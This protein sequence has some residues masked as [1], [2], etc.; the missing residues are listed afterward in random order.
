[1]STP[2]GGDPSTRATGP[3]G[4]YSL[5]AELLALQAPTSGSPRSSLM[6]PVTDPL[7]PPRAA[8]D[9]L[10][11]FPPGLY[12]TSSD[13]HL[14]RLL[15]VLLGD[16]GAGLLRK[17]YLTARLQSVVAT[18][19]FA[20]MDQLY[21][22]LFGIPRLSREVLDIA[23]YR[24]AA[25][26]E[27]WAVIDARDAAYRCRIEAFS[28]A[29]PLAG[30]AEG[31]AAVGEAMLGVACRVYETYL[32]VDAT[33]GNPGGAPPVAGARTYGDVEDEYVYYQEIERGSYAE[34]EGGSGDF[35]RTTTQG[36]GEFVLRPQRPISAEETY[37]LTKVLTRLKPAQALPTIDPA[38]VAVHTPATVRAVSADSVHWE[39]R[40]RVAPQ[41]AVAKA[42]STPAGVPSAQPR[43]VHA[44]YQGEAW[45]YNSDVKTTSAYTESA[46]GARVSDVDYERVIGPT[47]R[48][49]DLTPDR[50]VA[51]ADAIRRGRAASD[52]IVVGSSYD[53]A[54]G[55]AVPA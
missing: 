48:P 39:V 24:D 1:V 47:G 4:R 15:K 25:T 30:T 44:G 37:A 31:M 27:E 26:P 42:Y 3:G 55:T 20:E 11:H 45:S 23:P 49:V 18:M 8:A 36:R 6:E 5:V 22:Q 7:V 54:R 14:A 34:V 52:G 29:I 33:G 38:G 50:A 46:T 28:R 9:R 32:L 43:L 13:T 51:D 40:A 10:A 12:D 2:L 19:R 17:R 21:G 35:G 41:A 16:A 53:P